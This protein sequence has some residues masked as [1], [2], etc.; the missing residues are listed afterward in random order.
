ML[1]VLD[2]ET[3]D[4]VQALK[5]KVGGK[6]CDTADGF[7]VEVDGWD[8]AGIIDDTSAMTELDATPGPAIVFGWP[9]AN[10]TTCRITR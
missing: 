4:W 6:C 3:R 9:T 5:N 10:G 7:P 2:P 8:M 1:V